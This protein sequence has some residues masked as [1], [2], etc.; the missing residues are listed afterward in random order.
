MTIEGGEM[1]WQRR[2][3][4]PDRTHQVAQMFNGGMTQ[5]EI[6]RELGLDKALISREMAKARK[7]RTDG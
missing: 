5:Q 1:R 4:R 6:A 3:A 7:D 2:D